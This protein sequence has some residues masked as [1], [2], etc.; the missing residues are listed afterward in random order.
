[1][2]QLERK[3]V[4]RFE[5]LVHQHMTPDVLAV[6]RSKSLQ[7]NPFAIMLDAAWGKS[8]TYISNPASRPPE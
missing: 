5:T 3:C 4:A 1:M 2:K 8:G 7:D 6:L